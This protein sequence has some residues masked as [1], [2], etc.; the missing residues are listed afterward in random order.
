ME[1][2]DLFNVGFEIMILFDN[3]DT[4]QF[5]TFHFQDKFFCIVF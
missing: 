5:Y 3:L 4:F 1:C 2:V